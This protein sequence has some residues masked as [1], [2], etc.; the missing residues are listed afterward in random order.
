MSNAPIE[1]IPRQFRLGL[2]AKALTLDQITNKKQKT[3]TDNYEQS[4]IGKNIKRVGEQL[5]VKKEIELGSNVQII[6]GAHKG[7]SG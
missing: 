2:G 7:L 4:S 6:D 3:V 5:T 1:F